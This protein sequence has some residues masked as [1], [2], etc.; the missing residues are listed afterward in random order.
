M[1][2][3]SSNSDFVLERLHA[4]PQLTLKE[5]TKPFFAIKKLALQK[6]DK[7]FVVTSKQKQK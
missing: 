5:N 3:V 6:K 1:S 2:L 7:L 4:K